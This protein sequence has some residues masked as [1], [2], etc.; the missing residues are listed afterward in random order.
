MRTAGT[1]IGGLARDAGLTAD[2]LA[3][4]SPT[5]GAAVSIEAD[6]RAFLRVWDD[7]V[8]ALATELRLLDD[9]CLASAT[10]VLAAD[11]AASERFARRREQHDPAVRGGVV[12]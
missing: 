10:S 11:E 4:L 12:A 2:A 6:L 9:R 7:G 8:R 5:A 3:G 1:T